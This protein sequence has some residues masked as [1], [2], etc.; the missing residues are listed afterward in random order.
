MSAIA[1]V[2]IFYVGKCVN[3]VVKTIYEND[4]LYVVYSLYDEVQKLLA[5]Q[6]GDNNSFKKKI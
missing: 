6:R 1:S 3:E 2:R 4:L 5:L